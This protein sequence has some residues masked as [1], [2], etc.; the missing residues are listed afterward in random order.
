MILRRD[1]KSEIEAAI[2]KMLVQINKSYPEDSLIDITD[3]LGLEIYKY[4]FSQ[5]DKGVSGVIKK[6]TGEEKTQIYLNSED[7]PERRTFTLA[8]ELG[9]YILHGDSIVQLRV[10]QYVYKEGSKEA[11]EETEANYFAACLLMP[12]DKY[13]HVLRSTSSYEATAKYFGVSLSAARVRH[14]WLRNPK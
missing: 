5:I 7:T 9:H 11:E 10:D 2:D 4:D 14:K 1:K 6:G 12:E 3:S 8:H 13:L